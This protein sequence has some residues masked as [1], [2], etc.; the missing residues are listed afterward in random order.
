M[1]RE[2]PPLEAA[3]SVRLAKVRVIAPLLGAATPGSARS[4]LVAAPLPGA[5][6]PAGAGAGACPLRPAKTPLRDDAASPLRAASACRAAAISPADGGDPAG[7]GC[8]LRF[9]GVRPSPSQARPSSSSSQS[10]P[11]EARSRQ[12]STLG[13]SGDSV[14]GDCA[15][16]HLFH[17]S[18]AA[19]VV[20]SPSQP[21]SSSQASSSDA[22][23]DQEA[24]T[25]VAG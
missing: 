24:A 5:A 2:P 6:R 23:G 11:D 16:R 14:S 17:S 4:S 3:G 20:A 1:P 13:S 15:S 10:S 22:G 18:R 19:G 21:R 8:P 12:R 7:S 25:G 9:G